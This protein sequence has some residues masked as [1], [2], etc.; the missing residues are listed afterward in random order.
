[1]T[2][3]PWATRHQPAMLEPIAAVLSEARGM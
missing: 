3:L 2:W 1:M